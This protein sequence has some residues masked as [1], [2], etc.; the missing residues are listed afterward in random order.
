[1]VEYVEED[2]L[3]I[4]EVLKL[5][6]SVWDYR[7]D[8][9]YPDSNKPLNQPS[10]IPIT[11]NDQSAYLLLYK[12][13]I[14]IKG[15]FSKSDGSGLVNTDLV[16]LTNNAPMFLFNQI[17]YQI[18]DT[19]IESVRFPGHASL[20]KGVLTYP[21][22]YGE[23]GGLNQGW[24]LDFD[25][26]DLTKP[27]LAKKSGFKMRHDHFNK[28]QQGFCSFIVPL[29][30]IFGFMEDYK[31]MIFGCRHSIIF[32]RTGDK[33]VLVKGSNDAPDCKF[34]INSLTWT[35]PRI[36]PSFEVEA[37]LNKLF[38]S[39][40][41]NQIGFMFRQMDQIQVSTASTKFKWQLGMKSST[42]KPRYLIIG[43]QTNRDNNYNDAAI[44]DHCK[45]DNI[46]VYLN[47][48]RYPNIEVSND[49]ET[50]DYAL[51]YYLAKQFRES[52]YKLTEQY[53]DFSITL[54]DYKKYYPL[55]VIDTNKQNDRLKNSISEV[56][57]EA[58]FKRNVPVNTICYCLVLSDRLLKMVSDGSKVMVQY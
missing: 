20:M 2:Y 19:T 11:F 22:L 18:G 3:D 26:E 23:C 6:E 21:K 29:S 41:T 28:R 15:V 9:I 12:S 24:L 8:I 58:E 14:T 39:K 49:F 25:P 45:L 27:D 5:D 7:Y 10:Q 4:N 16:T 36:T 53:N 47:S 57:I 1:M 52:Q 42:E 44:F 32:H 48:T 54:E 40:W 46:A 17:D 34:L 43:F 31:K 38:I 50:G 33:N 30:H 37:K 35:I 51:S 55:F 13:F 56:R